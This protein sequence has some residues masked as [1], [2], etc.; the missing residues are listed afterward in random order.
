[1]ANENETP[2]MPSGLSISAWDA[3]SLE[4]EWTKALPGRV[5]GEGGTITSYTIYYS[6]SD[7]F[8]DLEGL[9]SQSIVSEPLTETEV[10]DLNPGTQYYF[11]VTASNANGEGP[12]SLSLE[13]HT[14][15]PEDFKPEAPVIIKRSAGD[16]QV[17]LTWTAPRRDWLEERPR[18]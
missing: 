7:D 8:L 3:D 4:L 18:P 10:T 15:T 14:N 16:G 2:G 9:K 12:V 17:E 1:M 11:A 6:T 5:K 13:T